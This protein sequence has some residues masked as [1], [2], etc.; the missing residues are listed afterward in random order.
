MYSIGA[1]QPHG[2]KDQTTREL[3]MRVREIC[4]GEITARLHDDG[5][6][7]ITVMQEEE[8][9]RIQELLVKAGFRMRDK[10]PWRAD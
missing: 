10:K 7:S 2:E 1:R 9:R 8:A 4:G 5:S 6:F 3:N